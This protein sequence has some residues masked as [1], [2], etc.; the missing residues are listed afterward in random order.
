MGY[1][2]GGLIFGVPLAIWVL[3]WAHSRYGKAKQ[4]RSV[5]AIVQPFDGCA[6]PQPST[7]NA[8]SPI[9]STYD[10][11]LGIRDRNSSTV[12]EVPTQ[13]TGSME[14]EENVH[15]HDFHDMKAERMQVAVVPGVDEE[16]VPSDRDEER[17]ERLVSEVQ[18]LRARVDMLVSERDA[19][20]RGNP[21][22]DTAT[23][24]S[25]PSYHSGD[26]NI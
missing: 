9:P 20:G 7:T 10:P 18:R 5:A 17:Y 22:A 25:P 13:T 6:M 8:I 11:E 24:I 14:P 16:R 2:G 23:V 4:D 19:S 15:D 3:R 1:V 21:F 26:R 12:T